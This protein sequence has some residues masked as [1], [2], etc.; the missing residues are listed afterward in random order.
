MPELP[1]VETV[2]RGLAPVLVGQKLRRFEFADQKLAV[3]KPSLLIGT[4]IS[5]VARNGKEV[6]LVF[7]RNSVENYLSIHL[8]MTGRLIWQTESQTFDSSGLLYREETENWRKHT[9]A[10][11]TFEEGELYFSDVRRFGTFKIGSEEILCQSLD[12]TTEQFSV[13]ALRELLLG[14]RQPIKQWLLRQDRLVGIGNIYASEILFASKLSPFRLAGELADSEIKKVHANTKKILELAIQNSGTT[15]SDF[16]TA[17]GEAGGFQNF[18]KV[19]DR[20]GK[21][22]RRCRA[23]IVRVVQAQRSTFYC[24]QCQS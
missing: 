16:L 1:E 23:A 14:S 2:C 10:K 6:L 24:P 17:S 11:F 12:P 18:L 9:R 20:E 21:P 3:F 15:F 7:S 13:Q 8:R 4:K 19:Y 5:K 22:C